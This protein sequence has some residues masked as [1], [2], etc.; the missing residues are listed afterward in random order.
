M[1]VLAPSCVRCHRRHLPT[2]PCWRGRYCTGK[3]RRTLTTKGR[4]CWLCGLDGADTA[5]H[6]IPRSRF[7]TD[8]DQNLMPAHDLC[9]KARGNELVTEYAD[10]ITASALVDGSRIWLS[11]RRTPAP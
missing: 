11:E 5:D 8:D 2:L 10:R 3:T 7:G 4:T 1:T 9:N 6:V